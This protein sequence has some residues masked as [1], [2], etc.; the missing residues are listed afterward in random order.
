M[1]VEDIRTVPSG[2]EVECDLCVV[3]SGPA[4]MTLAREFANTT[5]RV[6]VLESGGLREDPDADALNEIESVGWPRVMDQTL[7]RNR[8]FGGSSHTWAGRVALLD[9]A[10][11]EPRDW[12][13]N[14]GWPIGAADLAPHLPRMAGHL[15]LVAPDLRDADAVWRGLG[16]GGRIPYDARV[17]RDF[18]WSYSRAGR[19]FVRFGPRALG[20]HASNVTC[21]VNATVTGLLLDPSGRSV[22]GLA[23]GSR[24]GG[25]WTVRARETVL[26]CGAIENAR[27]LMASHARFR[28]GGPVGRYLMDHP[29]GVA[30]RWA[31][32]DHDAVQ[33][34]F[35]A[36]RMRTGAG[37]ATLAYGAALG[38]GLQREGRTLNAALWVDGERSPWNPLD[39]VAALARRRGPLARNALAALAGLP[40]VAMGAMRER[41]GRGPVHL[42]D[43]L[44]LKC[45]VEQVPDPD[46]RVTLSDRADALGMPLSRVDW[47]V[48]E[49]ELTTWRVATQAFVSEM[50]RVGIPVP[51]V[52]EP[53]FSDVAHPSGTTR[54]S[55]DPAAGVVDRHCAVHGV[56]GLHA[57]GSS[58]FPTCGH[59]N[60]TATVVALSVRLADRLKAG[61]APA[62]LPDAG[63]MA[64]KRALVLVTGAT[65]RIGS[66]VL[67]MLRDRGYAVRA[68]TSS[69]PLGDLS[70]GGVEWRR[71]DLRRPG[72]LRRHV[73]GC[74]AVLHLAAELRDPAWMER[75]NRDATR[76]LAEACEFVGV[77]FL[78]HA[79]TVSVYGSG[80]RR[81]TPEDAP[82]LTVDRDVR[83]EYWG[84]DALR[85]Y[86]RTKAAGELA[87]ADVVT[88]VECVV[89]RPT[90]VVDV[91]D[92]AA[93]GRWGAARRALLAHRLSHHVHVDDVAAAFVWAM[94]R[95]LAR[96][97]PAPGVTAYNL[98]DETLPDGTFGHFIQ[99]AAA[100]LGD[101]A[102]R[103]VP[104][105]PGALDWARDYA[106]YRGFPP[107]RPLGMMRFPSDRLAAAGF[108]PPRGMGSVQDEALARLVERW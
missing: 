43:T 9:D 75:V 102:P 72:G 40:R 5:A 1:R 92:V 71:H 53:S 69:E 89:F 108:A 101:R 55:D 23:V 13:P 88:D 85:A 38:A 80:L 14:S 54:M 47:R 62:A 63:S 44:H 70:A 65:G 93:V 50:A 8:V 11:F 48:G 17:L 25:A 106:R 61:M 60:P 67:A 36:F 97:V 31:V 66:R 95:C 76:E 7:V 2:T 99:R 98:S 96:D 32:S 12:V 21:L 15:G 56:D 16:T 52:L 84:D 57:V 41:S 73:A 86:G 58:V 20:E 28:G 26:C 104:A 87:L 77:R 35:S 59:A 45:M 3:G 74:E 29:R 42:M 49:R 37:R 100:V 33:A 91:D 81:D 24:G 18:F 30:A 83:S 51:E 79:S 90:V 19:D 34:R 4:G 103:P 107:R 94:G 78:G 46:S 6:V 64:G 39:A 105:L 82:R 27:L 10:D 68:L 22:E